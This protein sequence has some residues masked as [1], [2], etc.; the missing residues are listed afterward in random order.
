MQSG[1]VAKICWWSSKLE[2]L[3]QILLMSAFDL[4]FPIY[5][6]NSGASLRIDSATRSP[7]SH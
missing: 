4:P 5:Q 2:E 3:V 7:Q 1:S 6:A